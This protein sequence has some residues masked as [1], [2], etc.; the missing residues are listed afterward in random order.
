MFFLVNAGSPC[1]ND[2]V[3]T[4]AWLYI[5]GPKVSTYMCNMLHTGSC[6]VAE[7]LEVSFTRRLAE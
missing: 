6:G 1:V 5:T 4:C 7:Y 2:Y 3:C